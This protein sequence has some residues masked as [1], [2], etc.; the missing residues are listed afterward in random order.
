MSSKQ[1]VPSRGD[2][3]DLHGTAFLV[4]SAK[5]FNASTGLLIGWP[6]SFDVNQANNPFVVSIKGRRGADG[7]VLCHRPQTIEWQGS[8]RHALGRGS[9]SDLASASHKLSEVMS[10]D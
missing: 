5:A 6:I 1:V 4:A 9:Q 2:V 3:V 8:K 7:H 10:I